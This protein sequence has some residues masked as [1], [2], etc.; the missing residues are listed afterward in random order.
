MSEF[1][2]AKRIVVAEIQHI[3]FNEFLPI[4]LGKEIM[5][6]YELTTKKQV[7]IIYFKFW[8]I[9]LLLKLI[10]HIS[11]YRGIGTDMILRPIRIY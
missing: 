3:T 9:I 5:D 7:I 4:L 6:K 2:E 11:I 10:I 1:Q 8:F